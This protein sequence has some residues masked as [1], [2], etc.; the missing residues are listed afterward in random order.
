MPPIILHKITSLTP[1]PN[2]RLLMTFSTGEK[3]VFDVTPYIRGS[4][5]GHLKD[6]EYFKTVK[7]ISHNTGV[8]WPEGQDLAPHELYELSQPVP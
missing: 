3:K 4:W 2:Y 1:L 7:I 5:F 8:A 6:P